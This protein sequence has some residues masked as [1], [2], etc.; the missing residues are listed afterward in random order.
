MAVIVSSVTLCTI[1]IIYICQLTLFFIRRG[2][3]PIKAKSPYLILV[4]GIANMLMTMIITN[5]LILAN[6]TSGGASWRQFSSYINLIAT[7]FL[8]PLLVFPYILRAIKLH[9]IFSYHPKAEINEE[10]PSLIEGRLNAYKV[11][12]IIVICCFAIVTLIFCILYKMNSNTKYSLFSQVLLGDFVGSTKAEYISK[13]KNGILIGIFLSFLEESFL[14]GMYF[15]LRSIHRDFNM[16]GEMSVVT[17]VWIISTLVSGLMQ[18]ISCYHYN[19]LVWEVI[20]YSAILIRNITCLLVSFTLHIIYSYRETPLYIPY[21]ET[22]ECCDSLAL[23]LSTETACTYFSKFLS[24]FKE[25]QCYLLLFMSIK[26]YDMKYDM[27]NKGEKKIASAILNRFFHENSVLRIP[28]YQEYFTAFSESI[29]GDVFLRK[30]L[31]DCLYPMLMAKLKEYFNDFK[32]D[33][34]YKELQWMLLKR[35]I[36]FERLK[37]AGLN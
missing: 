29:N 3:Q 9:C 24:Q 17:L 15:L 11:I 7:W 8:M 19:E 28:E 33:T 23:T 22:I 5:S 20:G 16:M 36:C 21:G 14:I 6:T 10:K 37:K 32:Q 26:I 4:S 25:R 2:K 27:A 1:F 31:F 12:T 30:S 34:L 35:E 13:Y 18:I